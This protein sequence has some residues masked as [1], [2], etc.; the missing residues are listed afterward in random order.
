MR[1]DPSLGRLRSSTALLTVLYRHNASRSGH[2]Q[3]AFFVLTLTKST[4]LIQRWKL[5]YW[6]C[7]TEYHPIHTVLSKKGEHML[8]RD[9][10]TDEGPQREVHSPKISTQTMDLRGG[11]S[12]NVGSRPTLIE[13]GR[14]EG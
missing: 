11:I 4:Q 14:A 8:R 1:Y 2:K 13:L 5:K 9:Y 10:D 12:A 6:I 3:M 7:R